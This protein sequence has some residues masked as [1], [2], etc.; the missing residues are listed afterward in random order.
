MYLEDEKV[1]KAPSKLAPKTPQLSILELIKRDPKYTQLRSIDWFK[2]K[3]N[4]LGG[5]SP[6]VKTD[7]IKTTKDLQ[8]NRIIPGAMHMFGYDPKTKEDLPFYDK[9]PC[10][11]IFSITETGFYGI[12]FHYLSYAMRGRLYDKM[13]LIASRYHNNQQ[14]VL[15]LNWKLFSAASKFPEVR[16]AIKQYLYSH[17]TTRIIKV[18][19]EDWKTSI[20]LP[21][22]TFAK[23]SQ[24]YVARNSG[25]I[26]K[27]YATNPPKRRK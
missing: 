17:I 16:P 13:W 12:N 15:R 26:I 20:L 24:S 3:I 11:F 18:P 10:S 22:E 9:F 6:S 4:E 19:V 23:K 1:K 8:S 7:L 21:V 14:Q 5:N 2:A 27:R 25:Q